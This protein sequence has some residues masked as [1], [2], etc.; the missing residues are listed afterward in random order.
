MEK[1]QSIAELLLKAKE[2][3]RQESEAKARYKA[4][5]SAI[6]TEYTSGM[7]EKTKQ[8]QIIDA[9]KILGDAKNKAIALRNVF[10]ESMKAIRNDVAFAKE[11]LSFV[12]YKQT[13]SLQKVK[14]QFF[15]SNGKLTVKR[16]GIKDITVDVTVADW[17]AI[18]KKE[19]RKQGINGDDRVADNIVY[20]AKCIVESNNVNV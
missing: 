10:K 18:L 6:A 17:Q 4:Q 14:N 1:K 19:L 2:L 8:A 15:V 13:H 12:G 16:E 9:E 7:D 11:I 5:K 3:K 20:K